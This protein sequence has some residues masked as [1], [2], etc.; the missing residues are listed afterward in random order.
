MFDL[1]ALDGPRS[2]S[3]L[4]RAR[5][6]DERRLFSTVRRRA[7][8]RFLVTATEA[9]GELDA[10]TLASRFV[11]EL[12]LRWAAA[13]V[14]TRAED[15][16]SVAEAIASWRRCA[17]DADA[18]ALERVAA[19]DGLLAI[20]DDP[21][22]W[23]FQRDWTDGVPRD[24]DEQLRLSYSRLDTLENCELQYV[25]STELGLDPAGGYQAW[26]GRLVHRIIEDCENGLVERSA[27]H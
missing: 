7:R 22:R 21:D 18:S 14:T 13:P 11:D 9:H 17:A 16:I 24:D 15:P 10:V 20:G 19:L 12:G 6:A 26:V 8:R 27:G 1:A 3:E 25:L 23:W 4:N 5:L 2:R